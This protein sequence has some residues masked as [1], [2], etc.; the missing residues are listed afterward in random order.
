MARPDRKDHPLL[1]LIPV[2]QLSEEQK[3]FR[4]SNEER[5]PLY[6]MRRDPTVWGDLFDDSA[7]F[8][9]DLAIWRENG[10]L[11]CIEDN[12]F[13]RPNG[14]REQYISFSLYEGYEIGIHGT[15]C[16]IYGKTDAAI[17]ETAT[18]LW[19]LK[20]GEDEESYLAIPI[21]PSLLPEQLARILDANPLRLFRFEKGNWSA[22]QSVVLAT[23]SFPLHVWLTCASFEDNGTAFVD[24]METRQQYSFGMFVM[25]FPNTDHIPLSSDNLERFLKLNLTFDKL[26]LCMLDSECA[27]L[28]LSMKTNALK[29]VIELTPFDASDF[30]TLDVV[31]KDLD[32][33][34][35]LGSTFNWDELLV[36]LF[37]RMAEL[38]HF[39]RLCVSVDEGHYG[40]IIHEDSAHIAEAL[41]AA[42]TA[43]TKLE[44]LDLSDTYRC[45]Q[46]SSHFQGIFKAMEDHQGLR[47][48]HLDK[49]LPLDYDSESEGSESEAAVYQWLRQLLSRNRKIVV[50]DSSRKRCSNGEEIDNIYLLNDILNKSTNLVKDA[51]PLRPLLV[52]TALVGSCSG[53]FQHSA[54]LL[55]DHADMLCDLVQAVNI[56]ELTVVSEEAIEAAPASRPSVESSE[57]PK[58]RRNESPPRA[59]KKAARS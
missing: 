24:A 30:E 15:Y 36:A 35:I 27:L 41:I 23:R 16:N 48:F 26:E 10:T 43:N 25:T 14:F 32:L 22:E 55:S 3:A 52:T 21:L 37:N 33:R 5:I 12:H 1:E 4:P 29:Y 59:T 34:I 54:L 57:D 11:L 7:F 46:W 42:I 40:Y 18:F 20:Q 13:W 19:S 39:Q 44:C 31:A 38:G 53:K 49:L 50:Y 56:E 8:N 58:R 47:K 45:L 51:T 9:H 28:P 17:A 2:D 6:R